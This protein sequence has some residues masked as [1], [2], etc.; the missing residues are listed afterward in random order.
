MQSKNT[1]LLVI[2]NMNDPKLDQHVAT[3]TVPYGPLSLAAYVE[4]QISHI[5]VDI[6]DLGIYDSLEEQHKNFIEKIKIT[7]PILVGFSAMFNSS[8]THIPALCELAKATLPQVTLCI[9]GVFATNLPQDVF[10]MTNHIDAICHGEGEIPLADLLQENNFMH[11]FHNH[12]A[13]LT[14]QDFI[15]G[16]NAKACY[17]DNLDHIPMLNYSK[18]NID[19]YTGRGG[20]HE[21]YT[22]RALPIHSTRGCPYNCVFC[23]ASA[24]HGKKIRK[25]SAQRFLADVKIMVE[26]YGIEKLSIDDDQFLYNSQR[27]KEILKGLAQFSIEVEVGSGVSLRFIDE[28]MA[29]LMKQAGLEIATIAIESGSQ[30]MLKEVIDKPLKISEIAPSVAALKKAQILIHAPF[31]FGIPGETEEDRQLS[32]KLMLS[33]GLDWVYIF[34]AMPLKGSRLYDICAENGY[35]KDNN[36]SLDSVN[37]YECYISAPHIDPEYITKFAYTLNLEV[38]FV[39]NHNMSIGNYA[40]ALSYF[41]K[42]AKRYPKHAFAAYYTA[43]CL[44]KLDYAQEARSFM[45]IYFSCLK[46]DIQW[47][48][49]AKHF[50]LPTSS[51]A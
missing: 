13:W 12:P 34:I 30:R 2:P 19:N 9:G 21:T 40:K 10:A 48:Q 22:R 33:L 15:K 18:I 4:Q 27:A 45:N 25:M 28:E 50:H 49:H 35:F 43:K 23:S 1:V 5:Q 3:R 47:V 36:F 41:K 31:I 24:N 44:E 14:K 51:E 11:T 7:Q 38:N 39:H 16:K 46:N 42:I 20:T 6:L 32:R 29:M 17:V 37:P 8:F 26:K